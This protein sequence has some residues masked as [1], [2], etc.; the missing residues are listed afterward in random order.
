EIT[1]ESIL[2][3]S[4]INSNIQI[5]GGFPPQIILTE[6]AGDIARQRGCTTDQ[7]IGTQ[8]GNGFIGP[9]PLIAIQSIRYTELQSVQNRVLG[10]ITFIGNIP[11][12][13]QRWE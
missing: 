8:P 4:K 9:Y 5:P 12:Q 11:S 13:S 10:I 7:V 6:S 1:L 3:K 2:S